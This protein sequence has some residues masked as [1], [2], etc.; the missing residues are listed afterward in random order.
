MPEIEQILKE[1]MDRHMTLGIKRDLSEYED[2]FGQPLRIHG[3][4]I[5]NR[6]AS[7]ESRMISEKTFET[8]FYNT[9][10][11]HQVEV[12]REFVAVRVRDI[13]GLIYVAALRELD[14]DELEPEEEATSG[15]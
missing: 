13:N 6:L 4:Y 8:Y 3:F 1:L 10:D 2:H 14:E 5:H 11:I 7:P 9:V 15:E 12:E